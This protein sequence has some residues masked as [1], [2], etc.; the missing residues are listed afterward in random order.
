[1]PADSAHAGQPSVP[2]RAPQVSICA[3]IFVVSLITFVS[4]WGSGKALRGKDGSMGKVVEGMNQE[5]W[6]IFRCFGVGL[7][8]LLLG[9]ACATW[10]L[11]NV[12]GAPDAADNEDIERD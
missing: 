12:Y 3:N 5:R 11:M 7:I 8:C 6:L 9:V 10:L 4:V 2:L 1:M